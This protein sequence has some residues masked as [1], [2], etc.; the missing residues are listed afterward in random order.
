MTVIC[1]ETRNET[2]KQI[3]VVRLDDLTKS[4]LYQTNVFDRRRNESERKNKSEFLIRKSEVKFLE[5]I[6]II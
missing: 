3:V 1:H 6:E 5:W 4:A 2:K